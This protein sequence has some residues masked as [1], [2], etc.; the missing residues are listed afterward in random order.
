M[1]PVLAVS[2]TLAMVS[3]EVPTAPENVVPPEFVTVSVPMSVPIAP[4]T[5]TAPV[6]LNVR[7]DAVPE[8]VPVMLE[9]LTAPEPPVPSVSVT[10]SASVAAPSVIVPLPAAS[11][12]FP[13]TVEAAS[14]RAVFVVVTFPLSV[15]DPAVWTSPPVNVSVS[16]PFPSATARSAKGDGVCNRGVCTVQIQCEVAAGVCDCC[17]V[18]VGTECNGTGT[19]C[20]YDGGDGVSGSSNCSG[21]CRSA[22]ICDGECSRC[23]FRLPR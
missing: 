15:V 16:L 22:G 18:E 14:V 10:P 9:R 2:T 13:A 12:L 5:V 11:A 8:A 23:L 19:C 6:T 7:F 3:P 21:E 20:E 1:V 17:S 4:L